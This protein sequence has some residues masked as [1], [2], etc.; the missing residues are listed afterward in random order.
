MIWVGNSRAMSS[1]ASVEPESTMITSTLGRRGVLGVVQRPIGVGFRARRVGPAEHAGNEP[2]SR[3]G[4]DQG[5][6]LAAA[7][8]VIADRDL[9]RSEMV[10]D[11]LVDTLV[12][13][14]YQ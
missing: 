9:L 8:H 10:G 13:A 6:N 1:V 7:E 12:M 4:D 14:A 2:N 11:A 3:I 5:G